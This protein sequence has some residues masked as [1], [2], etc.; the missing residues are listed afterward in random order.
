[1]T[2]HSREFPSLRHPPIDEVICGLVFKPIAG[3]DPLELAGYWQQRRVDFPKK[4]LQPALLDPGRLVAGPIGQRVWM[5][6]GDDALV[7]QV[8]SDRFYLNWRARGGRYPRFG[9]HDGETGLATRYRA[10][11]GR[12]AAFLKSELGAELEPVRLEVAKVDRLRR[13]V[14]WK[15]LHELEEVLPVVSV[16]RQMHVAQHPS[17]AMRIVDQRESGAL[18][19]AVTSEGTAD[20][21]IGAVRLESQCNVTLEAL[22]ELPTALASA[23]RELNQA[24]FGLIPREQLSRFDG[25]E[26]R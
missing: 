18:T 7:L 5:I 8:Q 10:E 3:L 26:A 19:V 6:S 12:F 15:I 16:L 22:A 25:E 14:H 9:D 1:M 24:F 20:A 21:E 23:N 11:L 4:Q 17:F 2:D 13:G